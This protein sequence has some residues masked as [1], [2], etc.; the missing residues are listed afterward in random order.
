MLCAKRSYRSKREARSAHRLAGYRLGL[1]RCPDCGL[2][3]TTN[4]D[5]NQRGKWYGPA[6]DMP[7]H[8]APAMTLDELQA[9]AKE[10]RARG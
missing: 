7:G 1:Y 8:L 4:L 6:L 5:K 9:A 3:H 10:R 2:I